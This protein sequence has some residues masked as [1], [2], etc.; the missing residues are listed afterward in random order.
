M[1]TLILSTPIERKDVTGT[2]V[3]C[4]S[5]RSTSTTIH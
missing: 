3:K 2:D 4:A 5:H 1:I